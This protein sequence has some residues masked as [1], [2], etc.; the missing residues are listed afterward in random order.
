MRASL[1]LLALLGVSAAASL[2]VTF[3][4]YQEIVRNAIFA[5]GGTEPVDDPTSPDGGESGGVLSIGWGGPVY[6]D[7]AGLKAA[8]S[9]TGLKA[10][11]RLACSFS[12]T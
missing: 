6:V 12:A 1:R 5:T 9:I 8:D 11:C 3:E 7:L 10:A 2:G 4:Q